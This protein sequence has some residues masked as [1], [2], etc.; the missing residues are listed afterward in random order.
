MTIKQD[1]T[2]ER[3]RVVLSQ[4][5]MR[6]VSDPRLQSVTIT[7]VRVDPEIMFADVYV[8]ALGDE[9]REKEVM[10]ALERAK[11]YLRRETGKR[12]RL[13]IVPELKFHW[14]AAL[15]RGE[16]IHQILADLDIPPDDE[17]DAE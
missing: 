15:E 4:L 6:E 16:R 8:N 7:E 2:A 5:M 9:S 12:I 11:G 13:R 14:D 3:I 17:E 1:R 10:E